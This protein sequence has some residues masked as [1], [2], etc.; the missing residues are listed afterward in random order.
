M[1]K[2]SMKQLILTAALA[3]IFVSVGFAQG[4]LN[5]A[6]AAAGATWRTTN[7]FGMLA[8]GP[9]FMADLYYG[10]AGSTEAQLVALGQPATYSTIPAQA[11]FFTG[12]ARTIP[13]FAGGT[14]ISA[15][16]RVW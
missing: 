8:T 9:D 15:Q 2:H 14:T 16:V 12:G 4:T 6:S 13:G 7:A 3:I 10:P 11:G 5:F 1:H